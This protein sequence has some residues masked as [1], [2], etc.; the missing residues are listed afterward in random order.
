MSNLYELRPVTEAD[1]DRWQTFVADHPA[2]TVFQSWAWTAAVDSSFAY[3]P[4]HYLV[5]ETGTSTLVGAV[6]GFS[7]SGVGGRAVVNPF[8]EYGF[9]LLDEDADT[10]AVLRAL[11]ADVGLLGTRVLK[12]AG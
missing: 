5:Y 9:P 1:R 11:G 8:C 3:D 4:A 10:V 12:D 2:A 6:P 7:I